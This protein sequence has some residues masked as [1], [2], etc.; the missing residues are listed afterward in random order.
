MRTDDVCFVMEHFGGNTWNLPH[1]FVLK[2][3]EKPAAIDVLCP[4]GFGQ[5]HVGLF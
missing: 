3:K 2:K 4:S 1:S 5:F